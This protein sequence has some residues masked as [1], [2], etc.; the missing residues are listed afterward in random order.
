MSPNKQT[1]NHKAVMI[2]LWESSNRFALVA[3]HVTIHYQD[4]QAFRALT[5]PQNKSPPQSFA[6]SLE[7]LENK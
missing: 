5:A 4:A 2:S 3:A 6:D 7:T 1:G